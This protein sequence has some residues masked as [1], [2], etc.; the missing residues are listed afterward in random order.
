MLASTALPPRLA[1]TLLL[2]A[3]LAC[4]TS[5]HSPPPPLATGEAATPVLAVPDAGA[6]VER[7]P[8]AAWQGVVD[9]DLYLARRGQQGVLGG[10]AAS[11]VADDRFWLVDE[12]EGEGSLGVPV[13]APGKLPRAG[14]RVRVR[15]A[16]VVDSTRRWIWQAEEVSPGTPGKVPPTDPAPGHQI[17]EIAAPAEAVAVSGAVDGAVVTFQVAAAPVQPG[18][19]WKI[20]DGAGSP[21]VAWLHLPGERASYGGRDF[22]LPGER[23]QLTRGVTY[24]VKLG[25]VRRPAG[26][27]L[28]GVTALT[29]P[30]QAAAQGRVIAKDRVIAR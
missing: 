17:R 1:V 21:A 7:R 16:W 13:Q 12:T 18:A 15:G 30:R 23:W 28:L 5:D 19:P 8:I 2:A 20:A 27:P 14:D 9:R 22:R 24:W 10:I 3:T 4:G 6:E 29:A 26:D 25:K 11:A